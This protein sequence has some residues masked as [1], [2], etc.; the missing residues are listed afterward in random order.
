MK[1]ILRK[2]L[3]IFCAVAFCGIMS[4]CSFLLSALLEGGTGTTTSN[5]KDTT[6][7]TSNYKGQASKTW[8]VTDDGTVYFV[9]YNTSSTT[10]QGQYTGY[11]SATKA[12]AAEV[13]E[14]EEVEQ[15]RP[16]LL[17]DP[18]ALYNDNEAINR[19]NEELAALSNNLARER[20]A[21]VNVEDAVRSS[22]ASVGSTR[23]FNLL[24][25]TQTKTTSYKA[26]CKAVGSHC[27]V[28]YVD[29][30]N[31]GLTKLVNEK[32]MDFSSLATKFDQIYEKEIGIMGTNKYTSHEQ[33]YVAAS[34]KIQIV[35][36]DCMCDA[37]KNQASGTFGYQSMADL[38]TNTY[39]QTL[40]SSY[41]WSKIKS[42]EDHIIYLDS[43]FF[44]YK[45][46]TTGKT[47]YNPKGYDAQDYI[48]STISHEF[49]HLL[50]NVQ[51]YIINNS[52]TMETWFT[53]MLSLISEDMFMDYL[54]IEAIASARGRL[55]YFDEGY[56][57]GF[58]VWGKNDDVY[59]SYANAFAYGA[60]LCRNYGGEKLIKEIA[61]NSKVNGEAITAAL[62]KCGYTSIT[63]EDTLKE[64]AWVLINTK[65]TGI[66]LNKSGTTL[67][68]GI[69]LSPINLVY[70][71]TFGS[72]VE[73]YE[74]KIYAK[75][76]VNDIY[77]NGFTIHKVGTKLKSFTYYAGINAGKNS[78]TFDVIYN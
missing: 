17:R 26:T 64:F 5:G 16:S 42:N 22:A 74:P 39:L 49:N 67:T 46:K 65:T 20:G 60:Y 8:Q 10:V 29:N 34:D 76:T 59:Y 6:I 14:A 66:T 45:G 19:M 31:S 33:R 37:E 27:N 3:L 41:G 54:G 55:N 2:A 75:D 51:K 18:E 23:N 69:K 1:K 44:S 13:D 50:N 70:S 32:D 52:G 77:P 38:Y 30:A 73:K 56:N 71:E 24:D 9:K 36:C 62:N 4:S 25:K 35:V 21:V 12:K 28:W 63:F 11:V 53:E 47:T 7:K 15:I 72:T 57:Y 40:P 43:L 61:T 48:Y 68:S 78:I 58:T